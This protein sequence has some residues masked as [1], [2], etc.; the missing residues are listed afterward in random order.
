MADEPITD[1][2]DSPGVARS[3]EIHRGAHLPEG[4]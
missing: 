4:S 1:D 3:Y 2:P